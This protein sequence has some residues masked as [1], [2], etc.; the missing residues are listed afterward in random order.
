MCAAFPGD[1]PWAEAPA[2]VPAPRDVPG[3]SV[4]AG[5]LGACDPHGFVVTPLGLRGAQSAVLTP[6]RAWHGLT[7]RT[8]PTGTLQQGA[9]GSATRASVYRAPALDE[10][11]IQGQACGVRATGEAG[12]PSPLASYLWLHRQRLKEL[13]A[14][15]T[16]EGMAGLRLGSVLA[17]GLGGTVGT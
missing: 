1:G 13:N 3:L 15:V 11:T 2:P 8:A 12:S 16:S 4:R 10:A 9:H 5:V 17:E 14:C 6:A 7:R